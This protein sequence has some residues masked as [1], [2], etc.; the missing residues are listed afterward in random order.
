[1]AGP[2]DKG[3]GQKVDPY[4]FHMCWT[5]SKVDKLKYLQ[6]LG[7]W[8]LHPTCDEA[9]I[10]RSALESKG[11]QGAKGSL[12]TT[13]CSEEPVVTCHFRDK[14]SKHS[15]SASPSKDKNKKSFW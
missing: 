6:Q 14:A 10:R 5:A 15:C 11:K 12:V 2:A 4:A 13:C 3:G 9:S 8:F 1:M 7:G